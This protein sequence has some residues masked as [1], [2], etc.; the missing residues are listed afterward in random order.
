[1]FLFSKL[2][3]ICTQEGNIVEVLL[4]PNVQNIGNIFGKLILSY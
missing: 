4:I 2:S 1:M 3:S